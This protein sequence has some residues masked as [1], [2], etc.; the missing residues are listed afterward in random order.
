[1]ITSLNHATEQK[2]QATQK[3]QMILAVAEAIVKN[4]Q[5]SWI[6]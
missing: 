3:D 5:V 1:M 2:M 6:N 4:R